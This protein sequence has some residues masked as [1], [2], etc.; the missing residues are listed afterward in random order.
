MHRNTQPGYR[1]GAE[2]IPPLLPH[3]KSE[4]R[5]ESDVHGVGIFAQTLAVRG[6]E[7]FTLHRCKID[8]DGECTQ[9][10]GHNRDTG[11]QSVRVDS[12]KASRVAHA[13]LAKTDAYCTADQWRRRDSMANQHDAKRYRR[14]LPL[15]SWRNAQG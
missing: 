12:G 11:R 8:A 10:D 15:S 1:H 14:F 5:G 6:L 3:P 2:R 4:I 7:Y 9:T 13:G